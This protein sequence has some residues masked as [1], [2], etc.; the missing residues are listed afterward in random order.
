MK[1]EYF[2]TSLSENG[3]Y[4]WILEEDRSVYKGL[5]FEDLPFDPEGLTNNLIKGSIVYYQGGGYTVLGIS[6]SCKDNRLGAKSIFWVKKILSKE[7][8]IE[9]IKNN[10]MAAKIIDAMS[11]KVNFG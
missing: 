4:R 10:P 1:I 9:V 6:G 7:K 3:H 5:R 11:F 2:G 8:L